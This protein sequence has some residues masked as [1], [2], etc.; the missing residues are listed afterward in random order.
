MR[1][2][3]AFFFTRKHPIAPGHRLLACI[4]ERRV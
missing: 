2:V 3:I 4:D 1:Y